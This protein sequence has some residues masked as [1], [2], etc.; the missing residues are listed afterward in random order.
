[1]FLLQYFLVTFIA[2]GGITK[3]WRTNIEWLDV[4][5]PTVPRGPTTHP[6]VHLVARM[7]HMGGEGVLYQRSAAHATFKKLKVTV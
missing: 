7:R 1:M 4:L 5:P 2:V 6:I 3:W